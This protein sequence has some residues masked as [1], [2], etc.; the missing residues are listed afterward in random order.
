LLRSVEVI[1]PAEEQGAEVI[2]TGT[3]DRLDA[4]NAFF[5]NGRR[6]RAENKT[7]SSRGEFGKTS[8]REVLVVESGIVQQNLSSLVTKLDRCQ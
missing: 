5:H 2:G 7:G 8:D 1:E 6:I 3:G 4:A